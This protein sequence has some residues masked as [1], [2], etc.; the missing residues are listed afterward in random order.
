MVIKAPE[1]ITYTDGHSFCP[2]CGHGIAIRLIGEAL[3][4]LAL[5]EQVIISLDADYVCGKYIQSII[6]AVATDPRFSI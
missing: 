4:E 3:Q 5:E 2:G 6:R 1:R